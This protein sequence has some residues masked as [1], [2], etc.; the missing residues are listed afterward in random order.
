MRKPNKSNTP[1]RARKKGEKEAKRRKAVKAKMVK[2]KE[3]VRM[4]RIR[5]EEKFQQYLNNLMG[6]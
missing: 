6:N 1:E 5:K 3:A 4:D 2:R